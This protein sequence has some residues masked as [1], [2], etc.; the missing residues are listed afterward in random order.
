MSMPLPWGMLIFSNGTWLAASDD[1][2]TINFCDAGRS[3]DGRVCNNEVS[4]DSYRKE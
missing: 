3:N 1:G 2:A 4:G